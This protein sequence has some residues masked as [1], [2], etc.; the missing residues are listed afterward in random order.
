MHPLCSLIESATGLKIQEYSGH[1][2]DQY[3]VDVLFNVKD[4]HM[5]TGPAD[6]SLV[7]YDIMKPKPIKQVKAH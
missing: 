6:G 3:T 5:M 1:H 2:V 4:T 7:I